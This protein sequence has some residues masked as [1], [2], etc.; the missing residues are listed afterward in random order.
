A[1]DLPGARADTIAAVARALAG[2][3]ADTTAAIPTLDGRRQ[4]LHGAWRRAAAGALAAQFERG[5]RSIRGAVD[6]AALLVR[7]VDGL[8]AVALQ[9]ADVPDELP[10]GRYDRW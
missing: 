5:E 4:W 2:S 7:L 8:D 6:A 3:G 1:C 10:P 9:D